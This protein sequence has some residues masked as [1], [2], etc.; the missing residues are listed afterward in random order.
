MSHESGVSASDILDCL[1]RREGL[2]MW[3]Y[4]GISQYVL[5]QHMCN[6]TRATLT[7]HRAG[8]VNVCVCVCVCVYVFQWLSVSVSE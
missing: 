2:R 3:E 8:C 1:W 7:T 6:E 5:K 4:A